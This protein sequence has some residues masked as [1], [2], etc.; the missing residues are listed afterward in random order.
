MHACKCVTLLSIDPANI[1][2]SPVDLTVNQSFSAQ[3]S[4]TAFGNPIPQIVWSRDD[5]DN[6]TDN[7]EDT[8]SVTTVNNN[9]Q[10]MITSFLMINSTNRFRDEGVYNCTAINNVTNNIG[11]VNVQGAELVVQGNFKFNLLAVYALLLF[12]ASISA[13][14]K[15]CCDWSRNE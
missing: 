3:F 2:E 1:T 14:C 7:E 11:A 10:Y 13:T 9:D 6:I 5:H 4:C 8:I 15:C 12:S